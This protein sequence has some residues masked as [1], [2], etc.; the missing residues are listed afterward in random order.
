MGQPTQRATNYTARSNIE[1]A[2]LVFTP[3][4]KAR[5][6]QAALATSAEARGAT[7]RAR[8]QSCQY[9]FSKRF[10]FFSYQV[11]GDVAAKYEALFI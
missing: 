3:T 11:A 9:S 8:P 10:L 5:P 6:D 4:A 7:H 2:Q 1:P